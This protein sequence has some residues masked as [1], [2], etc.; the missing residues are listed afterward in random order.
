MKAAYLTPCVTA[1]RQDGS[2]D[3]EAQSAVFD[4]LLRGGVDGVLALGSMGEFFALT[5][6]RRRELAEFSV[7]YIAGRMRVL[8]GTASMD[9]EETVALSRH[10]LSVGADAVAVVSPYYVALS[11]EAMLAYY[12]ELAARVEGPVYLYNYPERTGCDLP[13]ETAL[14]IRRRRPNVVGIKD[15]S[16]SAEHTLRFVKAIKPEYPDFE[17]FCGFDSYFPDVVRGGGDGAVGGLSNVFPGLAHAWVQSFRR[18]DEQAAG[19]IAAIVDRLMPL[20]GVGVPFIPQIKEAMRR[21]G[22]PLEAWCTFP[23]SPPTA[24]DRIKIEQIVRDAGL[25]PERLPAGM[26]GGSNDGASGIGGGHGVD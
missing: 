19:R 5:A 15:S 9:F 8:V 7:T 20:Y 10:A 21:R 14:E 2:L 4:H 25:P 22:V 6:E 17:V 24:E 18:G 1:F 3:L 13:P 11:P 23:I 16:G 26:G 12:D